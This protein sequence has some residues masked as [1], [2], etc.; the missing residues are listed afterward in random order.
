LGALT[1]ALETKQ[2]NLFQA[3]ELLVEEAPG[4]TRED[5]DAAFS[6]LNET[7]DEH[8]QT[9]TDLEETISRACEALE[10][11]AVAERYS[12]FDVLKGTVERSQEQARQA[13]DT[14]GPIR[15]RVRVLER[16]SG[17][18]R[19]PAEELNH[20]LRAY[21][22]RD[23][24]QFEVREN[25]YVLMRSGRTVT[26]L[27]EGE[28]TA[29]SFL[30]F[31]KTLNG[32]DFDLA[33]GVVIID[34]PVSSLDA[35]GLFSA[36]AYLKERTKGC[37]QLF[38]LTHN[39]ALFRQVKNWFHNLPG[40][41]KKDL[42]QR[43]ARFFFVRASTDGNGERG[44]SIG[45]IDPLLERYESEYHYLFKRVHA[46]AGR[47]EAA[48]SLENYYETPNVARRLL[49]SF[50]AFRHPDKVHQL[51][52]TLQDVRFDSEKKTRIIRFVHTYSHAD[53]IAEPQHD[54]YVLSTT[55]QVLRD[56]LDL[57]R[58]LDPSHYTSMEALV[59]PSEAEDTEDVR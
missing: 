35:N 2:S 27:S 38:I 4:P 49:E 51:H 8:G 46:E 21:L 9:T 29:I 26:N 43:P 15:E 18:N 10:K 14:I 55:P 6:A 12:D 50:L 31:L 48:G 13:R 25:G 37:G 56:I 33:Q 47:A 11:S 28:K 40:Q 24:L 36:F 1:L 54:A 39:F 57:I 34:D 44:A 32:R 7:I 5:M 58:T 52:A 22:G 42:A 3:T 41:K 59:A 23:E 30:Y 20:E 17:E 53:F 19:R 45:P 16:E